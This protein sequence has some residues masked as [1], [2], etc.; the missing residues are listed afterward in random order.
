MLKS[1]RPLFQLVYPPNCLICFAPGNSICSQCNSKWLTHTKTGQINKIPL[2]FTN[3]YN[4][5]NARIILA[6]KENGNKLAKQLLA[7]SIFTSLTK[8][9]L[10]LNLNGEIALV[11]IP[12][13][14][15]SI[16]KRG[17]NHINDLVEQV[18]G[19]AKLQELEL[20]NLPILSITRKIKDQS[21][22]NKNQRMLNMSDAY[23][24][25]S[26][27]SAFKDLIIIDDLITTGASIQEGIRALSVINLRPVAIITA[28]AV[29]AHL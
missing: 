2:Y 1:L 13:S 25:K 17:R 14:S 20:I 23:L 21:N 24:A 12:S 28:C 11:S 15:D 5:E 8:A 22:L 19:I 9:K 27:K 6:A 4:A 10:D 3:H 29:G 26:P 16:R 7:N 18:V